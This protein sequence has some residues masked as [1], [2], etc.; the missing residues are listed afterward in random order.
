MED[1][2]ILESNDLKPNMLRRLRFLEAY[3]GV[4]DRDKVV[5][6]QSHIRGWLLRREKRDTD[7]FLCQSRKF[8]YRLKANRRAAAAARIQAFVRGLRLRKSILGRAM[9]R[10]RQMALRMRNRGGRRTIPFD[11]RAIFS[12]S[13]SRYMRV[14]SSDIIF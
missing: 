1:I 9:V 13:S 8:M 11:D 4:S 6:I 10:N 3:V 12:S 7:L 14:A 2:V 5:L